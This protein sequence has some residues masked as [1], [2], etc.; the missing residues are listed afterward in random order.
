MDLIEAQGQD[1]DLWG[2]ATWIAQGLNIEE[3]QIALKMDTQRIHLWPTEN[4]QL[5]ISCRRDKLQSCINDFLDFMGTL[6]DDS[7]DFDDTFTEIHPSDPEAR[8]LLLPSY[9]GLDMCQDLGLKFQ[10]LKPHD[11]WVTTVV[12][13]PTACGHWCVG[14][15][16]YHVQSNVN[17]MWLEDALGSK[18]A[19]FIL[20]YP[21]FGTGELLVCPTVVLRNGGTIT[22][23]YLPNALSCPTKFITTS[24]GTAGKQ[25]YQLQLEDTGMM[26]QHRG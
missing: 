21:P 17:L 20:N 10:K 12:A 24:V 26:V 25:H 15:G 5:T 8:G 11:L 13:D 9:L 14:D 4:Q 3:A 6:S 18:E 19:G 1:D 7:Q 16:L 23:W 2:S 22:L